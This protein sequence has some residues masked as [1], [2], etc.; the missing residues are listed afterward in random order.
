ML[1]KQVPFNNFIK[2]AEIILNIIV[3]VIALN[4]VYSLLTKP[5]AARKLIFKTENYP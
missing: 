4:T 1:T 5:A 2:K 3:S